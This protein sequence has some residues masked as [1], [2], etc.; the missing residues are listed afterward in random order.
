MKIQRKLLTDKQ[1]KEICRK[2]WRRSGYCKESCPLRTHFDESAVCCGKF[3]SVQDL[4]EAINGY[5]N[6]EVEF[7]I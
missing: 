2:F 5:W 1:K 6:E 7:D 3:K 4:E